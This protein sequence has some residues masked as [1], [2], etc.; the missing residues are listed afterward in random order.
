MPPHEGVG[1][2]VAGWLGQHGAIVVVVLGWLAAHFL[3]IRAQKKAFVNQIINEGRKEI[4]KALREYQE[5][6]STVS[7]RLWSL[8]V[9]FLE[10]VPPW[11]EDR[12]LR[13]G[14]EL[15]DLFYS[16]TITKWILVMEENEILF[17][18]LKR[19][20]QQL[21]DRQRVIS[22]ALNKFMG[23]IWT[24]TNRRQGVADV[25]A[26]IALLGEQSALVEYLHVYVQNL[27]LRALVNRKRPVP[28]PRDIALQRLNARGSRLE[29]GPGTSP[30]QMALVW[31][32][33]RHK[34]FRAVL[35]AALFQ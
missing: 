5:W 10:A 12:W 34:R 33:L 1:A 8:T 15:I 19:P 22:D 3:T 9:P 20:R 26:V 29:F 14:R 35:Q 6:C 23:T 30:G 2:A 16:R 27:A 31:R 4:G 18:E 24:A 28:G 21:A 13:E 7:S 32:R 17:P 25:Q 11:P